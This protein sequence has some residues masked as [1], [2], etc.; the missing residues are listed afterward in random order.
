MNQT[1]RPSSQNPMAALEASLNQWLHAL[2]DPVRAQEEVLQLLLAGYARTDYG[3]RQ[4]ADRVSSIADYRQAFPIASYADYQPLIQ[5]VMAGETDLL[6]YEPTL[7]WAITRGTTKGESKFIPMTPTDLRLRTAAGRAVMYY[8]LNQRRFDVLQG[9]NLNLNFP[10]VVGTIKVGDREV[11]YGYSSGI[12]VKHVSANTP[13]R[14][15][16]ATG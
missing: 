11:E 1:Q 16:P 12:Y 5:R 9:V 14:S 2:A 3:S 8:A 10:S 15:L 7:G 6:L 4:G 13:I